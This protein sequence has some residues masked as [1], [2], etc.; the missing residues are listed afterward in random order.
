MSNYGG[1]QGM[2]ASLNPAFLQQQAMAAATMAYQNSMMMAMSNAGSQYGGGDMSHQDGRASPVNPMGMSPFMGGMMSPYP[3][4]PFM[5]PYMPGM[6]PPM[7]QYG[8]F[9]GGN[10]SMYTPSSET[11]NRPPLG[12]P[13]SMSALNTQRPSSNPRQPDA[14]S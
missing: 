12:H 5:S 14:W 10:G 1:Q 11:Q 2:N 4:S 3:S 7:S 6:A 8:A 13:P 9:G